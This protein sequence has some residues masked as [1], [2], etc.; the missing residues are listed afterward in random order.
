MEAN[1]GRGGGGGEYR[2]AGQWQSEWRESK[3]ADNEKSR[4]KETR[5][6]R[7]LKSQLGNSFEAVCFLA[8]LRV[9]QTIVV[10]PR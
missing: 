2:E 9:T 7:C 3:S 6:S 10:G 5:S 4:E 8:L 1:R